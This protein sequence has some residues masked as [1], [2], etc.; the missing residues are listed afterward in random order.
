M[1]LKGF[2]HQ[3]KRDKQFGEDGPCIIKNWLFAE[4]KKMNKHNLFY[5]FERDIDISIEEE[6][7]SGGMTHFGDLIEQINLDTKAVSLTTFLFERVGAEFKGCYEIHYYE[8]EDTFGNIDS[9]GIDSE[10][11]KKIEK[12]ME[13]EYGTYIE[14]NDATATEYAIESF[15]RQ[16]FEVIRLSEYT[17]GL[18]E[19]IRG[20]EF[21]Y[22]LEEAPDELCE[23]WVE[24]CGV[25]YAYSEED[26]FDYL[27]F[28]E[29]EE[30]YDFYSFANL[31]NNCIELGLIDDPE[32]IVFFENYKDG[33][34][35][36][37]FEKVM[38]NKCETREV[39]F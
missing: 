31:I 34:I 28:T 26:G 33:Q 37:L 9:D 18:N 25:A 24:Q 20:H 5:K 11:A 22:K 32:R 12:F 17:F 4:F 19:Y 13:F 1:D 23:A 39:L 30:A 7:V 21:I 38:K 27:G 35:K 29:H 10:T 16:D 14:T 3:V 36:D 8:P 15:E 2:L 6:D